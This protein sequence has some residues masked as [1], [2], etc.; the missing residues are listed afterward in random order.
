[1]DAQELLRRIWNLSDT[2]AAVLLSD[3]VGMNSHDPIITEYCE[4]WLKE[5]GKQP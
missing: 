5:H 4:K 3:L 1:M 2:E